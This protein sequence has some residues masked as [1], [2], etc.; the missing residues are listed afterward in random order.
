MVCVEI[1]NTYDY[2]CRQ[3]WI[4][5]CFYHAIPY[6]F[7]SACLVCICI[8]A[9]L[10]CS[11]IWNIYL[12]CFILFEVLFVFFCMLELDITEQ[13]THT[14]SEVSYIPRP[15][16]SDPLQGMTQVSQQCTPLAP[17]KGQGSAA[18]RV[19]SD[20]FVCLFLLFNG[21]KLLYKVVLVSA[22]QQS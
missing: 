8:F 9:F 18:P 21:R 22:I 12:C 15:W 17:L 16:R 6:H 5:E 1:F 11:Y 19:R 20:L 13:Q 2:C 10:S 4:D 7:L 3:F 14:H